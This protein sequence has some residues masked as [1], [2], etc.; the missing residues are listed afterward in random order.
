MDVKSARY[1]I[2]LLKE[3]GGMAQ[4]ALVVA[5]LSQFLL[6]KEQCPLEASLGLISKHTTSQGS[7]P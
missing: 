6:Q 7:S 5:G 2:D 1:L 3:R 4:K